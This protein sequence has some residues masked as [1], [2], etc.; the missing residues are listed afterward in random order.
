MPPRGRRG[1]SVRLIQKT[2]AGLATVLAAVSLVTLSTA[3]PAS[4]VTSGVNNWSCQSAPGKE[5]VI[6]L[7]GL[8]APA[9]INWF[10]KAPIVA[11]SGY[12]VFTPQVGS[13]WLVGNGF[14]SMRDSS[15]EV[16]AFVDKVLA[17]T[18]ATKVNLVGHSMGTT[19]S[20][21]YMKFDGGDR[22]V[23]HFVGFGSNFH[24]TTLYGLNKLMRAIP[25]M[26][27]LVGSVCGSCE[28]FLPPSQFISDLEEG[29]ITRPGPTYTSI[30]SRYD[31]VVVPYTSGRIDEP[32]VTNIVLQDRCGLDFAGHL[33]QA[34]DPNVTNLIL[35]SLKGKTTPR[36][37][38]VPFFIPG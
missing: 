2:A 31:E 16:A 26:S 22:K 6:M 35:W 23:K 3:A 11:A 9:G 4:A 37:L 12:C 32:G 5:P 24:G 1:L 15:K 8:G 10:T 7:H 17:S 28:E 19:V 38:C 30:M 25:G 36:P 33:S 27:T 20:A 14:A 29:G 34:V 13:R 21:Y 18:G